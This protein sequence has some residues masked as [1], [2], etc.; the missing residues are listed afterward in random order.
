M[1]DYSQRNKELLAEIAELTD[2][3]ERDNF[4]QRVNEY[5][6]ARK[7]RLDELVEAIPDVCAANDDPERR[8]RRAPETFAGDHTR[9]LGQLLSGINDPSAA[10][11]ALKWHIHSEEER[12]I[13]P[14][15]ELGVPARWG[16]LG[17]LL[18]ELESMD[19][20]LRARWTGL[21]EK[22]KAIDDAQDRAV[23]HLK[24]TLSARKTEAEARQ[25]IVAAQV[26]NAASELSKLDQDSERAD[27]HDATAR[28]LESI[29][30]ALDRTFDELSADARAWT[31]ANNEARRELATLRALQDA[32]L[33]SIHRLFYEAKKEAED[34]RNASPLDRAKTLLR[35][36]QELLSSWASSQAGSALQSDAAALGKD[37]SAKTDA[38][39][40]QLSQAWDVFTRE[41]EG[42]FF[43]SLSSATREALLH[44]SAWSSRQSWYGELPRAFSELRSRSGGLDIIGLL[45]LPAQ[46]LATTAQGRLA[47]KER[48]L[49]D[50]ETYRK[51]IESRY[52]AARATLRTY[53]VTDDE[54]D[55]FILDYFH[56]SIPLSADLPSELTRSDK[57]NVLFEVQGVDR[58]LEK[59]RGLFEVKYPFDRYD[60]P[61]K[62]YP[63]PVDDTEREIL[64]EIFK[65]D[66]DF[67]AFALDFCR[68]ASDEFTGS[69]TRR[70]K[71]AL[72]IAHYGGATALEKARECFVRDN[73]FDER[74]L[75]RRK[76]NYSVNE[77]DRETIVATLKTDAE[78]DGF[79]VEY[80]RQAYN[81]F[82]STMGARRK[83][84]LILAIHGSEAV[85]WAK[86][87]YC[88][89]HP[90]DDQDRPTK[91]GGY[92]VDPGDRAR[93]LE[94]LVT[95]ADVE[96]FA[97]DYL[98]RA[99]RDFTGS[100]NNMRRVSLMLW[101]YGSSTVFAE[102]EKYSKPR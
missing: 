23:A 86:T 6:D 11:L 16:K 52:D 85:A 39:M 20:S 25:R 50:K 24:D 19:K 27:W 21:A 79:A 15:L 31:T 9:T 49:V 26:E 56:G 94:R 66:A 38:I 62:R 17:V 7:R 29:F 3:R 89:I 10:A 53:M 13:T 8:W 82:T 36:G 95:A 84:A 44:P 43:G 72:V 99:Q 87:Y 2:A 63:F 40:S 47:L 18:R 90:F 97:L 48:R 61:N 60:K 78:L 37:L 55:A 91:P 14:L 45:N 59:A 76:Y 102:L 67:S 101:H 80:A 68:R 64:L 35:E 83:A 5:L 65:T 34:F 41:H 57:M 30:A 4:T 1:G 71:A 73:P 58:V 28:Q 51:T 54:L 75:P 69:M 22:T 93:I 77:S 32:E 100:L 74:D 70:Q 33:G 98:P 12:F 88:Q 81:Q 96:A 42:R 92:P 46:E